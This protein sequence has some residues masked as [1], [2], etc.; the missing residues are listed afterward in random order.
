M[1]SNEAANMLEQFTASLRWFN[2]NQQR[3]TKEYGDQYIAV[4]NNKIIANDEKLEK[5]FAKLNEKKID[6]S[7]TFI[8]FVS[9]VKMVFS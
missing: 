2:Q 7:R 6:P 9:K 5:I 8:K 3:L 4:K 1:M